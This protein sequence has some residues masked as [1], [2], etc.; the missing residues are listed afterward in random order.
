MVTPIRDLERGPKNLFPAIYC[1]QI[2]DDLVESLAY[3]DRQDW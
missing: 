1:L 2:V 3:K